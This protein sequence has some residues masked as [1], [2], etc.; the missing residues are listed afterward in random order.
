MTELRRQIGPFMGIGVVITALLGTSLF[1]V[2]AMSATVAGPWAPAAWI[3]ITVIMIPIAFTFGEL[4]KRHPH[5]G[6]TSHYLGLAFGRRWENFAAWLFLAVL[7]TG[8]PPAA[9]FAAS[10]LAQLLPESAAK[11]EWLSFA[12]VLFLLCLTLLG[13]RA[14]AMM[15]T[16]IALTACALFAGLLVAADIRLETAAADA[17]A[18]ADIRGY[19]NAI[20]V[21]FWAFVGVE[22][23][24]HLGSEFRKPERDYPVSVIAGILIVGLVY[25]VA[26]LVVLSYETYGNDATDSASMALVF[27]ALF[28][29]AGR[30]FSSIMAFLSCMAVMNIYFLGFTRMIYSMAVNGV[31]PPALGKINR[32]GVPMRASLLTFGIGFTSLTIREWLEFDIPQFMV[33]TNSVFVLIYSLACIAAVVLLRGFPRL[34]AMLSV[35]LCALVAMTMGWSLLYAGVILLLSLTWDR[36]RPPAAGPSG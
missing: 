8:L 16:L 28:G 32:R 29:D 9:Y 7:P 5:A 36:W 31:L 20:A 27:S 13:I 11:V 10:Y 17:I 23:V 1:V 24:A 3:T 35:L 21:I 34:V 15:Q 4:G 30:R 26:V 18:D 33:F 12:V 2:P 19:F 14:S 25:L 6:G 22:A